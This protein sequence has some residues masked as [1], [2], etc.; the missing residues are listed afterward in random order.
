MGHDPVN[1]FNNDYALLLPL[2][3]ISKQLHISY[4]VPK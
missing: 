2:N 1:L 3:V 4:D